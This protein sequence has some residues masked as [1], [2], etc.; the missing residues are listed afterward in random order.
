MSSSQNMT[1]TTK[2]FLNE[3]DFT[4]VSNNRAGVAGKSR[5]KSPE[6]RAPK[7]DPK[8]NTPKAKSPQGHV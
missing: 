6:G 7:P 5:S 1:P 3:D 2:S 8:A 4:I